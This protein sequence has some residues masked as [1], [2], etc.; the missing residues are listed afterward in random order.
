LVA[1]EGED[2]I[3]HMLENFSRYVLDNTP[4]VPAAEE[5]IKTLRVLD[6]LTRS[7]REERVVPVQSGQGR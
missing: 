3:Q 2:Q 1:V 6:A 4:V 7:A 5:A